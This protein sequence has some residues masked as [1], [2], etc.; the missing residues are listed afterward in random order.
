VKHLGLTNIDWE[1]VI[2][3]TVPKKYIDLNIQAFRKGLEID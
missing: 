3:N 2:R 1:E